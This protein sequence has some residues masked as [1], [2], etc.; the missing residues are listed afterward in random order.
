MTLSGRASGWD[1]SLQL[2][3]LVL[4]DRLGRAR[5]FLGSPCGAQTS[6]VLVLGTRGATS[7]A[8][9]TDVPSV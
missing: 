3:W 1:V 9:T 7:D 8:A 2:C 6:C 5:V 4:E